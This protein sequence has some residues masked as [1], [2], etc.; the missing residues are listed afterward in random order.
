M[1][2]LI[3]EFESAHPVKKIFVILWAILFIGGLAF[4]IFYLANNGFNETF[5]QLFGH[6]ITPTTVSVFLFL[7]VVRTAYYIPVT[8]LM[9]E[10]PFI[11]GGLINGVIMSAIGEM[12]GASIGFLASRYYLQEF[13]QRYKKRS[14]LLQILNEKMNY[15]G[16]IAVM[17]LRI[18]PV[19]FDIINI[20]AGLSSM[21]FTKYIKATFISIWP[22]VIIFVSIGS[23]INSPI[24][25][26]YTVFSILILV[27]IIYYLKS[28]NKYKEIFDLRLKKDILKNNK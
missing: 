16:G 11:F 14:P 7:F 1:D 6:G 4:S 28:H 26:F 2:Y 22:K 15:F 12:I 25:T 17:I 27:G 8:I 3:E 10:S 20:G 24:V 19:S 21:N 23:A 13:F 9:I 18:S 5:D